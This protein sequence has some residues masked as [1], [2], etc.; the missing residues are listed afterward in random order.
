MESRDAGSW[1]KPVSTL[2][3]TDAPAGAPNLVEGKRLVGPLQG[4]GKL[5]QKTYRVPLDGVET[6]PRQVTLEWRERFAAFWPRGND[7]YPPL[8]GLEPGEVALL[9]TAGPGGMKLKTGVMVL[10]SDDESFTLM[11]PEGHMFAGWITFSA[12]DDGGTTVAQTQVLM[13]A[14]DPIS[15]MG[16]AMGGHRMENRFWEQTLANLATHLGVPAPEVSTTVVC[17]DRRRQWSHARN[18]RNS[19]AIRSTLHML[20]PGKTKQ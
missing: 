11:T 10:Y 13:R 4:F 16:L 5:W 9:Q 8:T 18:V 3:V 14:Q 12:H 1:A 7:F 19:V 2:T 17:V 20:K 6:T 15:E